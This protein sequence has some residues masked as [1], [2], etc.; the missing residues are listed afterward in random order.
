MAVRLPGLAFID[1][2]AVG[3]VKSSR[4]TLFLAQER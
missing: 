2:Q 1:Y 4:W 3:V